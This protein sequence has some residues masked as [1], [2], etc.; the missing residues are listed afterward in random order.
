VT[1]ENNTERTIDIYNQYKSLAKIS[2]S[3]EDSTEIA[4][5]FF[6]IFKKDQVEYRFLYKIDKDTNKII[7]ESESNNI[8]EKY[9]KL[10]ILRVII[11]K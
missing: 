7:I 6:C 11:N 9:F 8:Q 10:G 5:S 4:P 3:E 1:I 2:L